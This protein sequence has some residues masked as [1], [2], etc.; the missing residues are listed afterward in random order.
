MEPLHHHFEERVITAN[1]VCWQRGGM[2]GMCRDELDREICGF[3]ARGG[4][5]AVRNS[6]MAADSLGA[7]Y[8]SFSIAESGSLSQDAEFKRVDSLKEEHS[9]S[10]TLQTL[11]DV[12]IIES[13]DKKSNGGVQGCALAHALQAFNCYPRYMD[14]SSKSEFYEALRGFKNSGYRYLHI[15][16]HGDSLEDG[17]VLRS[18]EKLSFK[19][20]IQWIAEL[21]L[22]LTRLFLSACGAGRKDYLANGLF[23]NKAT[24]SVHSVLAPMENIDLIEALVFWVSFYGEMYMQDGSSMLDSTIIRIAQSSVDCCRRKFSYFSYDPSNDQIKHWI[25]E[26]SDVKDCSPAIYPC[27]HLFATKVNCGQKRRHLPKY[28]NRHQ[29]VKKYKK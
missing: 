1:N 19:C 11:P 7:V 27:T 10:K 3:Q 28:K 4:N 12:F 20:L 9:G 15:S 14:V 25:I 8:R 2:N 29:H 5:T 16:C 24:R 18:R 17:L 23:A 26:P 22:P 21:H 6:S 13:L